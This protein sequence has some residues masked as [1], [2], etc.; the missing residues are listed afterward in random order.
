[1]RCPNCGNENPPDYVFCDECGARLDVTGGD[2]G[3]GMDGQDAAP[4]PEQAGDMEAGSSMAGAEGGAASGEDRPAGSMIITPLPSSARTSS[5]SSV[6]D[7]VSSADGAEASMAP[8]GDG[9]GAISQDADMPVTED[10][11]S[12]GAP[13]ES[14]STESMDMSADSFPGVVPMESAIESPQT[15]DVS[16]TSIT[17]PEVSPAAS[18]MPAS[19][20]GDGAG[21]AWAGMALEHLDQAQQSMARGDYAG[22]GQSLSSLR[23]LLESVAQTAAS[24]LEVSSRGTEVGAGSSSSTTA[25]SSAPADFM[26]APAASTA[27][28]S[29]SSPTT[30][31]S[32]PVVEPAAEAGTL[33][34][35]PTAEQTSG[36][37]A[38]TGSQDGTS[39]EGAASTIA[40]LV[41]ISTG[42]ELPIPDQ[43]EITVGREDPSSGIFPDV[44]LT[45]YGGEEGGVSRRHARMLHIGDDY[46]VEDL[47][48]TNFTKLDGQRLPAHAREKV[49]DGARIDFGRV[50]VIFRRS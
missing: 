36:T 23:S 19:S 11:M 2:A 46:F 49:E 38:E 10:T 17:P 22:Y 44:D 27:V 3:A 35:M 9:A 45:P 28:S 13:G 16:A 40:R 47:Q 12:A 50:A 26:D 31:G 21:S 14:A 7:Q 43:E 8:A 30:A 34:S 33:S 29:S 6:D 48:S 18:G 32:V 24:T 1:M 42:A 15:S 41:V 5:A 39:G 20:G 37:E 25:N 4:Q